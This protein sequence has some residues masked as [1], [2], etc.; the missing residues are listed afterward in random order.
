MFDLVHADVWGPA[1]VI[2]GNGFKYFVTFIDDCTRMTWVYFLKNKSDV[3]D[4]FILFFQMI[5][6]QFHTT[7]KILRSDNGR[8][9]VNKTMSE[10]FQQKGLVHQTSCAYT[11]EQNG[12]AERKNRTILEA[13]R[14]LMI[15]SKVPHFLW[16][17]AVATAIFTSQT[18][19]LPKS[20]R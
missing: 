10:F 20:Y 17:E 12:V 5:Q 16:P 3:V 7:I 1:P 8:E 2:G 6:T 11:P 14:A 9:F 4:R 18:D 15:E 13:T 19:S